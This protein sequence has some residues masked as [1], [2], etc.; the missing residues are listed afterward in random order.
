MRFNASSI[1]SRVWEWETAHMGGGAHVEPDVIVQRTLRQL[2][3][4]CS[5]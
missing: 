5:T 2:F 3:E 1:R 4:C